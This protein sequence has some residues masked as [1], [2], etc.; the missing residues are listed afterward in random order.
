MSEIILKKENMVIPTYVPAPPI[1]LPMFFE[2]KPYQ[3]A[4][5]KLYPLPFSDSISDERSDV[6]YD[7]YT[8]ENEHI[9]IQVL[10]AIGGKIL[11]G[12]DKTGKYD[13]IYN[14]RV[15]KPALVGLAGPWISGGIEFNWPQHHRPTSFMPLETVSEEYEN[16]EKTVWMGEVD[17]LYRMKGMVGITLCP[18]RSYIKAKVRIYNRTSQPQTF[19]WW[20]NLAVPVNDSYRTIFPP[21]VEWVNDHDRRAVLEWPIAKGIYHTARPFDYGS[22]TDIS[23]YNSIRVPSSFLVSQGQSE[24]D[25]VGGY[26][27]KLQMGIVTVS[28]HHIAPGKKMWNWGIGDFGDMWCSNLTDE[29]GPYIELMTGVYTDNQPDFT[30]LEPYEAREFEQYWYPVRNLGG[31]VNATVNAAMNLERKGDLIFFGF[32]VTGSYPNAEISV[33]CKN[34]ILYSETV[35]LTP[36]ETYIKMLPLDGKDFYDITAA[37][38]SSEGEILVK[39][40]PYRRGQK[41]PVEV[42]RPVLRPGEINSVEELYIN[43][44]H[45]EQYKQHNYLPE[46]Y[47]LEGLKRDP[48]DSRCNMGMARLSLRCGDFEACIDYCDRAL[49]RLTSRNQHPVDTECMYMKGI[50]LKYLESYSKAYEVLFQA[51]WNYKTRSAAFYELACID[52]HRGD[53]SAALEKIEVSLDL[54]RKNLNALNLK[55]SILRHLGHTA[56]ARRLAGDINAQ[57]PLDIWSKCELVHH[58]YPSGEI[59]D[60]FGEKP[61]NYID[62]ACAYMSAGFWQ[63]AIFVLDLS[64]HSYPLNHYYKAFCMGK[65]AD[66]H[67]AEEEARMAETEKNWYC[68]PSRLEDIAVLRYSMEIY[69]QGCEAYYYLGCLWYDKF[70]YEDAIWCWEQC[71]QRKEKHA[72]ALRNLA[73]AYFDKRHDYQAARICMEKALNCDGNDPRLLLEYQQLLKNSDI[74]PEKRLEVYEKYNVLMLQRDDCYL[75]R[76]ILECM[77]GHYEQAI[78]MAL[79][80]RF[81]IYEGGEGKITKLHAWMYVLYG[82]KLF[83]EGKPEKAKEAYEKGFSIPRSYGEA[84]TYFNQEAHIFY[85]YGVLLEKQGLTERAKQA[86][87]D[88]SEYKA[89]VSEISLF[90]ALAFQKLNKFTE[91]KKI[92]DEMIGYGEELIKNCD[93]RSYYGVGSPTPMPFEYDIQKINLTEGHILKAYAWLGLGDRRASLQE[94]HMAEKYDPYNFRIYI[95][96]KLEITY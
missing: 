37:L 61:E 6:S 9:K 31:I 43:G 26:D 7:V 2:N 19:M 49:K 85:F 30:W 42:R 33:R 68:F 44:L 10:P 65:L 93:R 63:D 40:T 22:G 23:K 45:L 55:A 60:I 76:I 62:A 51:V 79:D 14:N 57:D 80:H 50:A 18:G 41:E 13:F 95:Y 84:K 46:D 5:G 39:Y 47:Y 15:I 73:I 11:N 16:G 48:Q 35:S 34:E 21:D 77:C 36:F 88:A 25:F 4:S 1:E 17:P 83:K 78:N 59:A 3:G 20:A 71:L 75:D 29:D 92:L 91:A 81:H 12:Y 94:I 8:L 66:V 53:F 58:G 90:R 89:A 69:P 67:G 70:R 27:E 74:S 38:I 72:K 54:N 52:A 24:M 56:E 87:E 28:D 32:Q 86:Y 82:N 96:H 64:P